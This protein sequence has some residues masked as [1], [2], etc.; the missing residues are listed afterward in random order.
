MVMVMV[1]MM[2]VLV[3]VLVL[4]IG[5]L[6]LLFLENSRVLAPFLGIVFFL[7]CLALELVV[8]FGSFDLCT[9]GARS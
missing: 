2:L 3:L 5:S 7:L 1:M 8:L 9:C 6:R 4:T